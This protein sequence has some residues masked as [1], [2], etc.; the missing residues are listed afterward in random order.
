[1]KPVQRAIARSTFLEIKP[2]LEPGTTLNLRKRRHRAGV[3]SSPGVRRR[4]VQTRASARGLASTEHLRGD[5]ACPAPANLSAKRGRRPYRN[6]YS[7]CPG[8]AALSKARASQRHLS[9]RRSWA[10]VQLPESRTDSFRYEVSL[11]RIQ[12]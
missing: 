8:T 3:S 2:H 7:I 9:H 10:W 6:R 4:L 12:W 5:S 11:R 1:M